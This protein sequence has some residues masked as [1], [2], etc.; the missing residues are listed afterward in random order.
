MFEAQCERVEEFDYDENFKYYKYTNFKNHRATENPQRFLGKYFVI[1]SH[2]RLWHSLSEEFAQ[3]EFISKKIPDLKLFFLNITPEVQEPVVSIEEFCALAHERCHYKQLAFFKDLVSAYIGKENLNT[4]K[5][6]S[7]DNSDFVLEECYFIC[8]TRILIHPRT[9]RQNFLKPY[10]AQRNGLAEGAPVYSHQPWVNRENTKENPYAKWS[11]YGMK[12]ARERFL[13]IL[14]EDPDLPEKIYIDRTKDTDRQFDQ[15]DLIKKHFVSKGYTPIV[16]TEYGYF[17][18]LS[19]FYNAK[20]IAGLC[21]T[22]ML[23]AFVCKPGTNLIQI[24]IEPKAEIDHGKLE[25]GRGYNY[26]E[27][28]A[29]ISVKSIDLRF[30]DRKVIMSARV[31]ASLERQLELCH[32]QV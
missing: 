13:N 1:T 25:F 28:I 11:L 19:F 21:G 23:N 29:P 15:E 17:K 8:D 5:I 7:A 31:L 24:F 4:T 20:Y 16:L 10:W 27:D 9:Y 6:Y 30:S 32:S 3:Y 26:L 14:K 18:Q 2:G 22:G 12:M